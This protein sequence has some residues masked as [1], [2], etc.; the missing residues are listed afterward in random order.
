[1]SRKDEIK[2]IAYSIWEQE[3]CP[4]GKDCEHWFRGEV[5]WEEQQKPKPVATSTKNQPKQVVQ[6]TNKVMVAKKKT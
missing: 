4:N 3:G 1:M 2:L 5:I 6:K